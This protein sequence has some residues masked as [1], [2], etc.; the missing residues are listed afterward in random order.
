M[1]GEL[2]R[3]SVLSDAKMGKGDEEPQLRKVRSRE[4][5]S[6]Y[7]LPTI[8]SSA[9]S[10]S[11]SNNDSPSLRRSSSPNSR[12]TRRLNVSV[13]SS[14]PNGRSDGRSVSFESTGRSPSVERRAGPRVRGSTGLWP[15][16]AL[17]S[18]APTLADHLG[19]RKKVPNQ[20]QPQS[21]H[22]VLSAKD[23]VSNSNVL[24]SDSSNRVRR[25]G[26]PWKE[27]IHNGFL[28]STKSG[29]ALNKSMDAVTRLKSVGRSSSLNLPGRSFRN[30]DIKAA[31][32]ISP[33]RHS[34]DL[35]KPVRRV[36]VEDI[37]GD[38]NSNSFSSDGNG[39]IDGDTENGKK[40]VKKVMKGSYVPARFLQDTLSR[41][42]R[43]SENG[44][45][46]GNNHSKVSKPFSS[47]SSSSLSSSSPWAMSPGREIVAPMESPGI[48]AK[49]SEWDPAK[50]GSRMSSVLN[51]GMDMLKGKGKGKSRVKG[52]VVAQ[53]EILHQLRMLHN[54]FM[55]WRFVN[56]RAQ[57]AQ[58]TQVASAQT[59]LYH[60]W[61]KTSELRS[62][63]VIKRVHF[64]KARHQ[65]KVHT[66]VAAH[67]ARLEEWAG[68]KDEHEWAV[69]RT[70]ECLDAATVR[71]PLVAGAK[72]DVQAVKQVV[73]FAVDVMHGIQTNATKFLVQAEKVDALLPELAETV[74][75]E[76]A[77]LQECVEL[78]AGLTSLEVEENSLRTHLVQL[79][80]QK[81]CAQ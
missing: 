74:A 53:E 33:G 69:T 64:H 2:H 49:H 26:E 39:S 29:P 40:V 44:H 15:A 78:L 12:S 68:L 19:I 13:E 27:N 51:F 48:V 59:S 7:M 41:L 63:V 36:K 14:S 46:P 45:L 47:S 25:T 37:D 16:S 60:V 28:S 24:H 17:N 1:G 4:V 75:Q 80:Q 52:K 56:A 32:L 71:V 23:I 21:E 42:R 11:P 65:Q 55:Q 61:L 79:N 70:M 38:I 34:V 6:R 22:R 31:G 43:M 3:N 67:A 57:A 50:T 9:A 20:A 62:R 72:A 30:N 73:R 54:R 8:S 35:E 81:L 77:L 66:V 18:D 10:V 5:S 76:I 58:E